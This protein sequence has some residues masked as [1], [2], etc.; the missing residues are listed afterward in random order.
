MADS[1]GL[2]I[3][4]AQI[5]KQL[6]PAAKVI[7]NAKLPSRTTS[8][9]RQVDVLVRQHVGQ[10]EMSIVIDSKD[11]KDP[12]DVKGVEEFHGLLTDI[13][14]NKGVLVCPSGF[15]KAAKERAEKLLIELYRP[16]DT[17]DHKWKA[18]VKVPAVCDFRAASISF[19]IRHSE[20]VH[21]SMPMNFYEVLDVQAIDGT[22]LGTALNAAVRRW[23]EGGFPIDE[24]KH[25]R[26][27][28]FPGGVV[29]VDNGHGQLTKVNIDVGIQV[30][31]QLFF[32]QVPLSKISG[33]VDERTGLLHTNGFEVDV[34]S[35][36]V[37]VEKWQ[38]VDSENQLPLKPVLQ[39]YGL[40]AWEASL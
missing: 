32:G 28:L 4:V 18:E 37:V 30:S 16:V 17:G 1:R 5:Q 13:V 12:V 23:N 11:Y 24:G 39:F 27:D 22:Q 19:G 8:A 31:R 10:Y 3:L 21:F 6:A 15:T 25:Q 26:I 40:V 38:K 20:P 2:E 9:T 14:A 33:F 36:E 7:H 29:K 34:V 35:P